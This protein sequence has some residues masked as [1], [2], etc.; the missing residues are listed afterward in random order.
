MASWAQ[1]WTWGYMELER[2][3]KRRVKEEVGLSYVLETRNLWLA[4]SSGRDVDFYLAG[5]LFSQMSQVVLWA[6]AG[7]VPKHFCCHSPRE[8]SVA[9][10]S[11]T[12]REDGAECGPPTWEEEEASSGAPACSF[13][14]FHIFFP[15]LVSLFYRRGKSNKHFWFCMLSSNVL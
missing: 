3:L 9:W 8:D 12:A 2:V 14:L 7:S 4:E 11:L 1:F 5:G 6:M 13:Q 15:S 10:P